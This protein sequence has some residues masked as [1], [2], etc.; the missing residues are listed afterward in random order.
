MI[1]PKPKDYLVDM[2][3][4]VDFWTNKIRVQYKK[5]EPKQVEWCEAVKGINLGLVEYVKGFHLAGVAY[6]MNGGGGE[7]YVSFAFIDTHF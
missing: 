4:A 6:K 5:T 1:T 7:N 2:C 3:G